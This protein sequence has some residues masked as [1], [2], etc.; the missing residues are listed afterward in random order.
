M[1]DENSNLLQNSNQNNQFQSTN[2][3]YIMTN[4]TQQTQ[5]QRHYAQTQQHLQAESEWHS[6]Q[7]FHMVQEIQQ[8]KI[9][10]MT[11]VIL[12][13]SNTSYNLLKL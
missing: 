3:N 7:Y 12:N 13:F 1:P 6:Q 4:Q 11:S 9:N 5:I 8:Q 10:T 2:Q